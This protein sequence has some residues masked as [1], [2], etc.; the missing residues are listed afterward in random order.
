MLC[1]VFG[2]NCNSSK[3]SGP[4]KIRFFKFPRRETSPDRFLKWTPFCKRKQF[5][6]GKSLMVCSKHFSNEDFNESDLLREKLMPDTKVVVRLKSR[7]F[8]TIF[9]TQNDISLA[10]TSSDSNRQE[11][12]SRKREKE[13]VKELLKTSSPKKKDIIIHGEVFNDENVD[14]T[15]INSSLIPLSSRRSNDDTV[16]DKGIQ[17]EI[18]NEIY[19]C[20]DSFNYD[21]S[22]NYLSDDNSSSEDDTN[23]KDNESMIDTSLNACFT[24]FWQSLFILFKSCNVCSGKIIKLK[25][26]VQGA[27]LSINT[28]CEGHL[29]QWNSQNKNRKRPEGN[30]LIGA[31]LTLSGIL[32]TQMTVF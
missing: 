11:R 14:I 24:V 4:E 12:M 19:R 17:C 22:F 1:S 31:S 26:F 7:I 30:I 13:I 15:D 5:V 28:I 29:Y 27:F 3:N 21:T 6:P 23:N 10:S 18:G 16:N 9:S 8:S 2:C 25:H 20:Q 32:F